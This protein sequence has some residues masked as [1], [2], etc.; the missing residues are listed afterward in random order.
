MAT[1]VQTLSV[2]SGRGARQPGLSRYQFDSVR[3]F[4]RHSSPHVD[5]SRDRR[6]DQCGAAPLEEGDGG[7][8]FLD[9]FVELGGL[10]ANRLHDHLQRKF[11]ADEAEVTA[12]LD[13]EGLEPGEQSAVQVGFAVVIGQAQNS[14]M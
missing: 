9:E 14:T 4:G 10:F 5:L 13:Q 8:G 11:R 3:P 12:Q 7:L 2:K 1:R 6:R